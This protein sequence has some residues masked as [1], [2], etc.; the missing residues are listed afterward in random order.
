MKRSDLSR[1]NVDMTVQTKAVRYPTDGRLYELMREVLVRTA[2]ESGINL[3]HSD[4]RVGKRIFHR[5]GGYRR[6]K[7]FK[8]AARETRK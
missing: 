1:V 6:A 2:R 5:L 3:R 8:R 7:P 4:E